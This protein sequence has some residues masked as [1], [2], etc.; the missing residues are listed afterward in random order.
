MTPSTSPRGLIPFVHGARDPRRSGPFEAVA[1]VPR[2]ER[3]DV[4]VRLASVEFMGP[5][6]PDAGTELAAAGCRGVSGAADVPGRGWPCAQGSP[7]LMAQMRQAHPGVAFSLHPTVGEMP[8]VTAVM[9]GVALGLLA[10][11]GQPGP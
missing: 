8:A 9:A 1:D 11:E 5:T 6:R 10:A 7:L 4:K 2:A 3:S